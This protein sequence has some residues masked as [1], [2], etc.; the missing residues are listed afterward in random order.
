ML[1]LPHSPDAQLLRALSRIQMS[2]E[3][4]RAAYAYGFSN[5]MNLVHAIEA[6]EDAVCAQNDALD[7]LKCIA[8][9]ALD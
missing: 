9:A 3:L 7:A 1:N 4:C 8:E 5:R 2:A 6:L